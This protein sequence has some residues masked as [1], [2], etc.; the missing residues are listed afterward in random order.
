MQ[1]LL[2]W[3]SPF[4]KLC[5]IFNWEDNPLRCNLCL[6]WPCPVSA[7]AETC[8][9]TRVFISLFLVLGHVHFL[10]LGKMGQATCLLFLKYPVGVSTV[11]VNNEVHTGRDWSEILGLGT[12]VIN[13][14]IRKYGEEN[15]IEFIIINKHIILI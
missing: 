3:Q 6:Y 13:T 1:R 11:V 7:L 14:Y 12:N 2:T 9:L 5:V 8:Y 15:T 4:E 10:L